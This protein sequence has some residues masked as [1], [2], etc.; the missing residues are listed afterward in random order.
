[1]EILLQLMNGVFCV[2]KDEEMTGKKLEPSPQYEERA[3]IMALARSGSGT[4]A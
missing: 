4:G 2:K 1:M 3:G